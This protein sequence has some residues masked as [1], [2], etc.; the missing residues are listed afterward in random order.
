[1]VDTALGAGIDLESLG[2][3]VF[4]MSPLP[5]GILDRRQQAAQL[6]LG[7]APGSAPNRA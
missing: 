1:V 3:G 4:V 5:Q 7:F 2:L 6:H